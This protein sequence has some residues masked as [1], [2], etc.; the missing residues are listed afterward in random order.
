MLLYNHPY[1]TTHGAA[2]AV[3]AGHQQ[4]SSGQCQVCYVACYTTVM[5]FYR[6]WGTPIPIWVS[7]DGE[8]VRV[9]GSISELEEVAGRK[10]SMFSNMSVVK[11]E[12]TR[13]IYQR[14][15][16]ANTLRRV[17]ASSP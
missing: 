17:V 6:F 15:E 16:H 11:K 5:S 3:D 9:I 8:E 13:L 2:A 1:M 12:I 4:H 14:Q 7:E 10:V